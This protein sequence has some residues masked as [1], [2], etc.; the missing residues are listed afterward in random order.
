MLSTRT[1]GRM[2]ARVFNGRARATARYARVPSSFRHRYPRGYNVAYDR[3]R[4]WSRVSRVCVPLAT[5]PAFYLRPAFIW[6]SARHAGPRHPPPPRSTDH[7]PRTRST[8]GSM[9]DN[10]SWEFFQ[11]ANYPTSSTSSRSGLLK[12]LHWLTNST[13]QII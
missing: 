3:V 9:G 13:V 12:T 8:F 10:R 6:D 1:P 7:P 5:A 4:A 2:V 11:V